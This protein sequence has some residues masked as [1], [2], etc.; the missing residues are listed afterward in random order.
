LLRIDDG[1]DDDIWY[2]DVLYRVIMVLGAGRGPI[3]SAAIRA[4]H[5]AARKVKI[6][7]VEKNPNAVVTYVLSSLT[8]V[9]I[10]SV[11]LS[12]CLCVHVCLCVCL[13]VDCLTCHMFFIMYVL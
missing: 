12:V 8:I 5:Q 13:R 11:C 7:A 9:V 6:Y 10:L 4:S 3:V 1:T 2:C